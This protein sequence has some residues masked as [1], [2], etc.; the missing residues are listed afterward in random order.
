M[1]DTLILRCFHS[2]LGTQLRG[3]WGWTYGDGIP[4]VLKLRVK[5]Q[6][7]VK[8]IR[9]WVRVRVRVR[10]MLMVIAPGPL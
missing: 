8:M 10:V 9:V 6:D 1:K 2:N 5:G 7:G 4:W 3:L